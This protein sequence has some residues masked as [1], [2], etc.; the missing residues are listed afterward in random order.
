MQCL[1]VDDE[2][3]AREHLKALLG[4]HGEVI[5]AGEAAC[6]EDALE[7]AQRTRCQLV[8]LDI[9]MPGLS[10]F[11]VACRLQ[12]LAQPPAV[13]FLTAYSG[14]SLQAYEIGAIDYL[15]KPIHRERLA[16]SL[17]RARVRIQ[18]VRL[19]QVALRDGDG[20]SRR[21]VGVQSISWFTSEGGRTYARTGGALHEVSQS[22]SSLEGRLGPDF[23]RSHRAY[24]VNLRCLARLEPLTRRSYQ[25][26]FQDG[27][28]APLS[29]NYIAEFQAR[30]PD[31]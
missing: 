11:E 1:I 14:F 9:E 3:P 5:V 17:E 21:V 27:S 12:A 6:G 20:G 15:L 18:P 31:L 10:G 24:L 28:Q 13:I 30:V 7:L 26:I 23:L 22:L 25:L 29:R 16:T 4:R 8:F 19:D 2:S